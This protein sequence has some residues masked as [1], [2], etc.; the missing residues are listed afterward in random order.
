MRNVIG[1]AAVLLALSFLVVGCGDESTTPT[2][3]GDATLFEGR[4]E[5]EGSD[6]VLTRIQESL[7]VPLRVDLIGRDLRV[8]DTQEQVLVDVAVV[9]RGDAPLYPRALIWVS[10]FV[11][12]G[13]FLTDAD[14]ILPFVGPTGGPLDEPIYAMDYSDL[15][16]EDGVL[17]PGETTAW[18]T[19]TFRDVGLASFSFQARA[20]FSVSE[21]RGFIQGV[22]FEDLNGNGIRERNE[23][24]VRWGFIEATGP[25]G[26]MAEAHPDTLGVY[27][28]P[29][30]EPGLYRLH[31]VSQVDCPLCVT[32][33][34]PLEVVLTPG[35][36][37]VPRPFHQ[38]HFGLYCGPCP[39]GAPPV[40][41]TPADPAEITPR[42]P[43]RL[44]E[45][46]LAGD[47]LFLRVGFSGCAPD[48]PFRLVAGRNFMESEP[49]QT[50]MV[51]AH[52]DRGELC[53]GWFERELVF[54]LRPIQWA[55][56]EDYG[57]GGT[58][59]LRLA[60]PDAPEPAWFEY[61]F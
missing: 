55:Y 27:R 46:R 18:R 20:E 36:D 39:G 28:V 10:G 29:A 41:L 22:L 31:F 19:W 30:S 61:T 49:V 59:R 13:V 25:D 3:T 47:R 32:T 2:P 37:G 7:P 50:W 21:P 43:W 60:V 51:L 34:D 5:S 8:D 40:T 11:P 16:G 33:P 56:R 57:G 9:N 23:P 6:F 42:S 17:S 24:P 15:L 52:D 48:H 58:V 44:L 26:E 54:D 45:G 38:A 12:A 14:V 4:F 53:D 1:R 35:P